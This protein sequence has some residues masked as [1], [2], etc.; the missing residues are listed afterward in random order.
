[1]AE[2]EPRERDRYVITWLTDALGL[3]QLRANFFR[4]RPGDSMYLH[5][6]KAQE[7]LFFIVEGEAELVVG[8]ERRHVVA[9]DVVRVDK[10]PPRQLVQTG[11]VGVPLAR[12]RGTAGR[13]RGRLPGV[14]PGPYGRGIRPMRSRTFC[15]VREA[16]ASARSAPSLSTPSV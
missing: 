13:R 3:Q 2:L 14:V 8:D 6:H 16:M 11:D 7:E 1:M 10:E 12:R 9:G 15:I 4:F 5:A